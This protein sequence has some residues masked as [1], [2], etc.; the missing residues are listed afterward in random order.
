MSLPIFSTSGITRTR[1]KPIATVSATGFE[2]TFDSLYTGWTPVTN[3]TFFSRP[4]Q[5]KPATKS[6]SLSDVKYTDSNFGTKIFSA[7]KVADITAGPTHLR[8]DYPKRQMF[9]CDDTRFIAL[10]S[11][12]YWHLYNATTFAH[13]DGGRTGT[14][15]AIGALQ[16]IIGS[17]SEPTWHPTDPNKLWYTADFGGLLWYELDITTGVSTTLFNFTGRLSAVGLGSGTRVSFGGEGRP[18]NDGEYWGFMVTSGDGSTGVGLMIYRRSTD[19]IVEAV[20]TTNRPNWVG[21]S[22]DGAYF[23]VGWHNFSGLSWTTAHAAAVGSADGTRA[24]VRGSNFAT[25]TTCDLDGEHGDLCVDADG[26]Q[27]WVSVGYTP[28]MDVTAGGNIA[29]GGVYMR[30]LSDGVAHEFTSPSLSAYTGIDS[31][32]HFS[33]C[34]FDRDGWC[35]ITYEAGGTPTAWKDGMII[36][37]E[38]TATSPRS[39]RLAHHQS[40]A[41]TYFASPLATPNRGLTRILWG[42]DFRSSTTPHEMF[43][44]GLPSDW[45]TR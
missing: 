25:W 45:D 18:S 11:D 32:M 35:V 9:N 22:Q 28:R 4:A 3:T 34:G 31:A 17:D 2:T 29:D 6:S 5:T 16:G 26:N 15:G 19:T 7:T 27:C 40:T 33:G 24:Y 13:I 8:N 43:M 10:T 30:R 44:V 38:L 23:I 14:A 37:Q 36:L 20:A 39:I 42:S 1:R 41:Y 21:M 12:S